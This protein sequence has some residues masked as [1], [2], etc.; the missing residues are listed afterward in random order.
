MYIL[1][2]Y[3][4]RL[5]ELSAVDD[6]EK[7]QILSPSRRKAPGFTFE[8]NS[9]SNAYKLGSPDF[10]IKMMRA[11][12]IRDATKTL[13]EKPLAIQNKRRTSLSSQDDLG[14]KSQILGKTA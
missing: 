10:S 4:Q 6:T 13:S 5:L 12:T 2:F 1:P 8:K 7:D 3:K 14:I 11:I 9:S